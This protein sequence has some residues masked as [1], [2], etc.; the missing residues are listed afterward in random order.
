MATF[1]KASR[2]LCAQARQY[3]SKFNDVVIVSAARTPM[4]SFQSKLAPLSASELGAV[5][6]KAAVQRAGNR[7]L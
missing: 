5:A 2:S 7:K 6:I 4:G 1:L 3:S